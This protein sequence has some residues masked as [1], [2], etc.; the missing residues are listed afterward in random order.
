MFCVDKKG[1]AYN[2]FNKQLTEKEY[3]DVLS[4]IKIDFRNVEWTNSKEIIKSL[5]DS[6]DECLGKQLT[7]LNDFENRK[8]AW[9]PV[10]EQ[11][12][13]L[14]KLSIWDEEARQVVKEITG[15]DLQED[16]LDTKAEEAIKYLTE[17]G[18]LKDGKVLTN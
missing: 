12:M 18:L 3:E 4:C 9:R 5:K 15:W 13:C 2:I 10:K 7:L 16:I 6:K 17:K 1:I 8:E 14:T 11:L